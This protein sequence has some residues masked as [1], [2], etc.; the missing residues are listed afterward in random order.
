MDAY[1]SSRPRGWRKWL[2]NRFVLVP[3]V[4]LAIAGVSTKRLSSQT[5]HRGRSKSSS[6]A[7][8]QPLVAPEVSPWMNSFCASRNSRM[9]GASTMMQKA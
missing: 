2:L 6:S 8:V 5:F 9:P 7:I 1:S 4:I 3:A